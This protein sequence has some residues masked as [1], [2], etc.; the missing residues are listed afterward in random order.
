MKEASFSEW[1]EIRYQMLSAVLV[2]S[3]QMNVSHRFFLTDFYEKTSC[4]P[5]Q[6]G[7]RCPSFR[8]NCM[9]Y[10]ERSCQEGTLRIKICFPISEKNWKSI[11]VESNETRAFHISSAA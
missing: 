11:R 10:T 5:L 8:G 2:T 6:D 1:N 3:K 4:L 9:R 7:A